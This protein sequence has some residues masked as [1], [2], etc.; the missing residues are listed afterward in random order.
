MET[1]VAYDGVDRSSEEANA[2]RIGSHLVRGTEVVNRTRALEEKERNV[3]ESERE[4]RRKANPTS[5]SDRPKPMAAYE[6]YSSPNARSTNT[7]L[8]AWMDAHAEE[9]HNE[10]RNP[11]TAIRPTE[12]GT[13][14]RRAG[15]DPDDPRVQA[16]AGMVQGLHNIPRHRSIHVGGF[17][18][19]QEPLATI[20]PI[21]PASMA[22]R[23]VIQWEKDDLD[24]V[25]LVKIDLL[26]LG[27]L[28]LMQDCLQ[29]IRTM[30]GAHIDLGTLDLDDQAVYDDL[31]AADT[32]GVFQV[33]SRAQMNT[34]PRLK[35]R[36]FYD[37]VVE[38]ALIRPGPIQGDM[39]HP[40]LRRRAGI[41]EVTY[42]HPS[43]E[44]MLKR[45]LGVPL[46]QEQ[47]M[48]V[49]IA[50]AGFHRG[51]GRQAAPRDGA[52]AEPRADGGDLPEDGRGDDQERYRRR[53]SRSGSTTRSM[54]LPTTA[55]PSR[56]RR[57]SRCSCTHPRISGTTTRRNFTRR[58][59][60]RSR[61]AST[62]RARWSRMRSAT[63]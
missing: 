4:E 16:L 35:P 6:P 33:E 28:T 60:M 17:V 2:E 54:P 59:S 31:C 7:T 51:S 8:P 12:P 5:K 32:I 27:M 62:R 42:P 40:F 37:L 1:D 9:T 45:T 36:C 43:L 14:L 10:R 11:S 44:P 30:R 19:T 25:G 29:Y 13:L 52:Q 63:A 24:P 61:W 56:T 34:L 41:E 15:L 22:D 49:A 57:A 26:G 58:F 48:Q 20:V 53:K 55:F 39:V 23:T 47:G 3:R 50:A 21:E 18:L 46:F 38:V